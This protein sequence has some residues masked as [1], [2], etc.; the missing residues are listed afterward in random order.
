MK[1]SDLRTGM[2]VVTREGK[3][4][5]GMLGCDNGD[6]IVS[7]SIMN[8]RTTCCPLICYDEDLKDRQVLNN[9]IR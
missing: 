6:N 9:S 2:L 8:T 4:G 7:D 5:I 3:L 1:K